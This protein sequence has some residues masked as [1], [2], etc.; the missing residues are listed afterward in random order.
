M[1]ERL[2]RQCGCWHQTDNWPSACSVIP[3]RAASDTLPVPYFISDSIEP[4]QSMADGRYYSSKAALRA[5]YRPSG[6]PDGVSYVEVGNEPIRTPK[7]D[8]ASH[9]KSV[10]ESLQMAKER[11]GI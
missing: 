2:C 6:N 5:T 1:R 8:T 10:R 3:E 9:A 7:K 11:I 4:L